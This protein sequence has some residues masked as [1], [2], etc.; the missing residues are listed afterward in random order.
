V[1]Y[2]TTNSRVRPDSW[3]LVRGA[4][5]L[6]TLHSGVSGPRR[7]RDL[8]ELGLIIDGSVLIRNGVIESVGP[9]RRIENLSAARDANV[10]DARGRVVMPAFIDPHAV[11]VPVPACRHVQPTQPVRAL[12]ASRLEA[13]ADDLL[14]VMARHGTLSVGALSGYACD[15]TGELKI[16]RAMRALDRKPLDI[17]SI[18]YFRDGAASNPEVDLLQIVA[19]RK[20]AT[21]AAVHCGDGSIPW[22]VAAAFLREAN[23]LHLGNRLEM[24]SAADVRVLE[25][26]LDLQVF[27]IASHERFT[28]GEIELIARSSTIAILLPLRAANVEPHDDARRFIDQ[29]GLVALGSGLNP[30]SGSTAS[31]QTVVQMAHEHLDMSLTEAITAATVNAAWALGLGLR[32]GALDH[33]KQADLLLLNV[34]DYRE[35]P[36]FTGTN[37]VH[38]AMKSG[39]VLFD[40]DFPGWPRPD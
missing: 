22:P 24:V 32:T 7:A 5:Q 29:G 1:R 18:F 23:A 31:M 26:A 30:Q 19:N 10:I 2:N 34:S 8:S 14:K 16:L 37:L 12:P 20:L 17:A 21:I 27:S 28:H 11:L 25:E 13:Q 3:T 4:R 38:C 9:T 39:V 6:L 35:I 15:Q 33:G 36:L 40:E